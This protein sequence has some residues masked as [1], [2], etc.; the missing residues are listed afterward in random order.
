MSIFKKIGNVIS[1]AAGKVADVASDL[2][3]GIAYNVALPVNS[4]TGHE[5]KPQFETKVGGAIAGGSIIGA[6]SLNVAAKSFADSL[7][8]GKA[9]ELGNK[10]RKEENKESVG[11]YTESFSSSVANL[12]IKPLDTLQKISVGGAAAIGSVLG[13]N[14]ADKAEQKL[15]SKVSSKVS[16]G[17]VPVSL[18]GGG[19]TP[20]VGSVP[21]VATKSNNDMSLSG[22]F[23]GAANVFTALNV[24]QAQNNNGSVNVPTTQSGTGIF[25]GLVNVA[26]G[27]LSGSKTSGVVQPTNIASIGGSRPLTTTLPGG[28]VVTIPDKGSPGV[29]GYPGY[30]NPKTT[31]D[32]SSPIMWVIV[33]AIGILVLKSLGVFKS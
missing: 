7:T 33:A 20:P 5:Y 14:A 26:S 30:T 21:P 2:G 13:K 11:N 29:S 22:I 27:L 28:I 31:S 17:G 3:K 25:S 6:N 23:Q 18:G 8:G 32:D 19:S 24:G 15:Q 12:N 1:N 9:T 16:S 10:F 4:I